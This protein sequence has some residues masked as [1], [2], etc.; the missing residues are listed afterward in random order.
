MRIL[1]DTS[2]WID[3]FRGSSSRENLLFKEC[4]Q[5]REPIFITGIIAQEILQGLRDDSQHQSILNYLLLFSRI[6]GE[7]TDYLEAAN[8]YRNLRKRGLTIRSPVDCLIAALAIKHEIALLH[9]DSDFALISQ[10]FPLST[11]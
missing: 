2:V 1:V 10:H 9:K 6:E 7:F 11:V 5:R 4:L 8:I 3:F